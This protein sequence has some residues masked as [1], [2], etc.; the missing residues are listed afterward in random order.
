MQLIKV[1]KSPL[2]GSEDLYIFRSYC[3]YLRVMNIIPYEYT[4]NILI[5]CKVIKKRVSLCNCA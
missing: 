1:I 4:M 2:T 5:N 3:R